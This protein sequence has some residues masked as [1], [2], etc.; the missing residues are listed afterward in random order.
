LSNNGPLN[1]NL[2]DEVV[3]ISELSQSNYNQNY[4]YTQEVC[5]VSMLCQNTGCSMLARQGSGPEIVYNTSGYNNSYVIENP[6]ISSPLH[7]TFRNDN[8]FTGTSGTLANFSG[9][10]MLFLTEISYAAASLKPFN[11]SPG[12]KKSIPGT[13]GE[14]PSG[15][16]ITLR[17]KSNRH[18][19]CSSGNNFLC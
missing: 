12:N 4:T 6:R 13:P 5:G 3:F 18:L 2:T 17:V 15:L 19:T 9:R 8:Y 11:G 16:H 1:L 7:I 10:C 14:I